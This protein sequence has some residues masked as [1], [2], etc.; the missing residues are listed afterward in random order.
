[1]KKFL[2]IVNTVRA[3]KKLKPLDS[4]DPTFS[5]QNDIGFD[6]FDLAELTV[7]IED[8]FGID[9]F[10][11]SIVSTIGEITNKLGIDE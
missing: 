10:E 8:E 4:I 7:R 5:L 11:D 2:D 6:S 1:M 9:V 3:N